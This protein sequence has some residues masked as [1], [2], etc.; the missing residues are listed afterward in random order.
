MA[1][2]YGI[3]TV[4][5]NTVEPKLL[6]RQIGLHPLETLIR[7]ILGVLLCGMIGLFVFLIAVSLLVQFQR[8]GILPTPSWIEKQV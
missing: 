2:L 5:R 6:G 7:M 3:I 8:D 1:L 4:I